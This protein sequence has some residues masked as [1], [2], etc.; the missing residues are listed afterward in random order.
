M[1]LLVIVT[2]SSSSLATAELRAATT[3]DETLVVVCAT[4]YA[5]SNRFVVDATSTE[6]MVASWSSLI[7]G[8]NQAVVS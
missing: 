1:G 5:P 6:A 4:E 8:A 3:Q 7:V 2:G